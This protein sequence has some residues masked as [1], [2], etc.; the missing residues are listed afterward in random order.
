LNRKLTI[1]HLEDQPL[2][3]EL[4]RESLRQEGLECDLHLAADAEVFERMLHTLAPDVVLSDYRVPGFDGLEALDLVRANQLHVPFIFVSGSMG[5]EKAI[6]TLHN[7]ATDYVLKDRLTRL[8]PAIRR[9]LEEARSRREAEE[10]ARALRESEQRLELALRGADLGTWDWDITGGTIVFNERWA[11]M[12]DLEPYPAPQTITAWTSRIHP[13]DKPL[14]LRAVQAHLAGETDFFEIEC[15]MCTPCGGSRWVLNRGRVVSRDADGQPL[16]LTGTQLDITDRK[17]A[18][19]ALLESEQRLKYALD[20]TCDGL[21]DWDIQTGKVYF[22]PQW[23]RLLSYEPEEVPQDIAFFYQVLHPEDAAP[24]RESVEARFLGHTPVKQIEIRLRTKTGEYRWF[25]DRGK[26]VTRDESGAP[27]RMVGTITDITERKQAEQER[28]QLETQLRQAHKM[29]ALG[30]LAGGI[31][32]DFNNILGAIIGFSE[33]VRQDLPAASPSRNDLDEVLKAAHRAKLLVEQILTFSRQR[34][35]Y[36]QPVRLAEVIQEALRFLRATIPSSIEV[37]LHLD[38]GAPL[39]MADPTQIHQI[40]INLAANSVHA[41]PEGGGII[42]ITTSATQLTEPMQPEMRPGD[43]AVLTVSDNGHGMD[44]ALQARIFDPFF[45]TKGPGQGTGLGLAVVHGI[46][47]EHK[48][49]IRVRSAPAQGTH[50]EVY[51]PAATEAPPE[52]ITPPGSVVAGS[53]RRVMLVDDEPALV[54]VGKLMLERL[55]FT[56]EAFT[57]SPAAWEAFEASPEKYDLVISDQT[58]PRLTGLELSSR[59]LSRRPRLP[60]ILITGYHASANRERVRAAGVAELLM[61]PF[62]FDSLSSV[63]GNVLGAAPAPPSHHG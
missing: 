33:L 22:S 63:I 58:M 47:R 6:E 31:A 59:I 30:T 56:V 28:L 21:W 55:G 13:D 53:G 26:V 2:D 57:E 43:Y 10:A 1:L 18:A 45:T 48:G 29:E 60:V 49:A 62:T 3:A 19:E 61:K 4:I 15:R 27:L 41:I 5:E 35:Q 54:R 7:G 8:V 38:P 40:I 34:P 25:S 44:A 11:T 46:V 24:V 14:A 39:V 16:R 9:A 37:R 51:L 12:L 42:E 23:A 52:T 32:H 17:Q 36:L 50:I 20:A